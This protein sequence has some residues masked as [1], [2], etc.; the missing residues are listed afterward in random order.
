M[1]LKSHFYILLCHPVKTTLLLSI[2]KK[3]KAVNHLT[4][5]ISQEESQDT[6]K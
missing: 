6:K 2:V 3:K 5:S 4:S 1:K